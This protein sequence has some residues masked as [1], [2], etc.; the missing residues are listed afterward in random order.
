MLTK[1]QKKHIQDVKYNQQGEDAP[2][3]D[4]Q[5]S[6]SLYDTCLLF[7]WQ[8]NVDSLKAIKICRAL[9]DCYDEKLK[10]VNQKTMMRISKQGTILM[11]KAPSDFDNENKA[12]WSV[13]YAQACTDI[14][15][16]IGNEEKI[17]K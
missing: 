14:L 12:A 11:P 7:F 16:A 4:N 2:I 10:A 5:Q 15:D 9:Q 3:K 1:K 8:Q 17:R 13:G 6:E